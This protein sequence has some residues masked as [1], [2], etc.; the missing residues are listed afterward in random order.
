MHAL[1]LDQEQTSLMTAMSNAH[2]ENIHV[3][4][5]DVSKTLKSKLPSFNRA[6]FLEEGRIP[7]SLVT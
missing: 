4:F 5:H 2:A 7:W 1:A 6:T 3:A